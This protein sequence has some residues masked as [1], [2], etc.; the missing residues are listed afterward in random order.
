[1][2]ADSGGHFHLTLGKKGNVV[3]GGDI[4]SYTGEEPIAGR[5]IAILYH[6]VQFVQRHAGGTEGDIAV[7]LL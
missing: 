2:L 1:M 6:F 4:S 5:D 7:D 3:C